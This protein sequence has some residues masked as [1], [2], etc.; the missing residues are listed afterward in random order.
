MG[1][2]HMVVNL[3]RHEYIMPHKLG[4]GLKLWEQLANTNPGVGAALI[5]L[6]AVSNGR[7][8]GD[9]DTSLGQDVIGRWGGDRIAIIGDYAEDSDLD[10]AVFGAGDPE[11][12]SI[13]FRCNEPG[14]AP[15]PTYA[16]LPQ[17]EDITDL[18]VPLLLQELDLLSVSETGW[19]HYAQK[20]GY[21]PHLHENHQITCIRR[22]L[23]AELEGFENRHK[24]GSLNL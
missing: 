11:P 10:N 18:V 14:S 2:Y 7:G 3:D 5:A 23:K 17:Y 19:R 21:H 22:R 12:S 13:Y 9:L 24:A 1:Q 15:D 8:G 6:L 16:H 20:C 4:S